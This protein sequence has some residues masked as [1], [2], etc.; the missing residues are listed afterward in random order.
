MCT[1]IPSIWEAS[2]SLWKV[3]DHNSQCCLL[4]DLIIS[5]DQLKCKLLDTPVMNYFED[6][7]ERVSEKPFKYKHDKS[8]LSWCYFEDCHKCRNYSTCEYRVEGDKFEYLLRGT[9]F[10]CLLDVKLQGKP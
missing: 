5:S 1:S 3:D 6:L 10:E 2:I 4:T 7:L 8:V 9:K